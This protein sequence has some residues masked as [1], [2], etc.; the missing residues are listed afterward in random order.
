MARIQLQKTG[1]IKPEFDVRSK[2]GRKLRKMRS[3]ARW[4]HLKMGPAV[5]D[6][7]EG[8]GGAVGWG[9]PRAFACRRA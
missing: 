7:R 1:G 6:A 9:D 8:L 2:H 4:M 5:G 3:V